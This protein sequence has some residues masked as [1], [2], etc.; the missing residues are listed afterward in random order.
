MVF[1]LIPVF[2]GI[3]RFRMQLTVRSPKEFR[4]RSV[5]HR[6]LGSVQ[7]GGGP[8]WRVSSTRWARAVHRDSRLGPSR[9][10]A[11]GSRRRYGGRTD[12]RLPTLPSAWPGAFVDRQRRQPKQ[13]PRWTRSHRVGQGSIAR[14]LSPTSSDRVAFRSIWDATD[15]TNLTPD[16]S[17]V[18][19]GLA[20]TDLPQGQK[21]S[22]PIAVDV[23]LGKL[24]PGSSLRMGS[25]ARNS[26]CGFH[27]VSSVMS[28][29]T[30]TRIR[31]VSQRGQYQQSNSER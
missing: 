17:A 16:L 20:T 2:P 27:T 4:V 14:L 22:G 3:L 8:T 6:S 24:L 28:W 12:L 26:V 21:V 15:G 9:P 23:P 5:A 31:A 7:P 10:S 29:L 19:N 18:E 25:A 13:A 11:D 1:G 30:M